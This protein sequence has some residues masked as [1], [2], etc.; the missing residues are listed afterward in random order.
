VSMC[1]SGRRD[2]SGRDHAHT[3]YVPVMNSEE[4]R[5]LYLSLLSFF[6]Y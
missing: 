4:H 3:E 2:D 1:H 5:V 6:N